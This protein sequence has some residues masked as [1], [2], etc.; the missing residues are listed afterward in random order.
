MVLM[1]FISVFY[2]KNGVGVLTINWFR[3]KTIMPTIHA[4]SSFIFDHILVL[5]LHI[6]IYGHCCQKCFSV[7]YLL[8]IVSKSDQNSLGGK[9]EIVLLDL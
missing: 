4:P 7:D 3:V 1:I 9:L 2:K 5:L 8:L 6:S